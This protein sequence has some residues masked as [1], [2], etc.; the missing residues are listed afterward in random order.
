MTGKPA[1][2]IIRYRRPSEAQPWQ[3]DSIWAARIVNGEAI[4]TENGRDFVQLVFPL[5]N[6]LTWDSNHR[7]NLGSINLT[8]RNV[9]QPYRV[10]AKPFDETVTV[11]AQPDSTLIS[12]TKHL[13]VYARQIGLIYKERVN[14]QF[15][16]AS[17]ACT[18]HSQIDYGTQQIYRIRTYGI[19]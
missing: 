3:A 12:L 16:I 10:L 7:N 2:R 13:D 11:S 8:A 1:Y 5:T 9:G 6:L 18:G 15:C 19:D 4:R 17:P 14:L